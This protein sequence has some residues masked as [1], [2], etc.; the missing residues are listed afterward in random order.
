[1]AA[2]CTPPEQMCTA[3]RVLLLLLLQLPT[4]GFRAPANWVAVLVAGL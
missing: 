3:G 4:L 1:M 2:K